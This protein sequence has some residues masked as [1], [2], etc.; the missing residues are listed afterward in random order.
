VVVL[1]DP[2]RLGAAG[3][4]QFATDLI[5]FMW[6]HAPRQAEAAPE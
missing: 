3:P 1:D 2:K 4:R 5:S 6:A